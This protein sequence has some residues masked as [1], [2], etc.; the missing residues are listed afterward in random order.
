[1]VLNVNNNASPL[2]HVLTNALGSKKLGLTH[3]PHLCETPLDRLFSRFAASYNT[4]ENKFLRAE[5]A[6]KILISCLMEESELFRPGSDEGQADMEWF[7]GNK[8]N[9]VSIKYKGPNKDGPPSYSSQLSALAWSKNASGSAP[10]GLTCDM[11][12]IWDADYLPNLKPPTRGMG[13]ANFKRG[14][15]VVTP[16]QF[17]PYYIPVESE[18]QNKTNSAFKISVC[19]P[20]LENKLNWVR[21][22]DGSEIKRIADENLRIVFEVK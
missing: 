12:I 13:K 8:W 10:S 21:N 14:L 11:L 4:F 20:A 19:K 6:E 3:G 17:N 5:L 7:D 9:P 22:L 2:V 16:E 15:L 18:K 1:M